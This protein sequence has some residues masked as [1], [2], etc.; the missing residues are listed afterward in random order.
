MCSFPSPNSLPSW[1]RR[2]TPAQQRG[3]EAE[4]QAADYLCA[5]G[6][7]VIAR[8]IRFKVGEL[9]LIMHDGLTI[10]FVEVR[11]RRAATDRQGGVIRG[12]FG[13]AAETISRQKQRRLILAAEC[14]LIQHRS[15]PRPPCRFDVVAIDGVVIQWIP[16]AFG[17][18]GAL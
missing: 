9:D 11:S 16:N 18:D 8:N 5:R 12:R 17:L 13:G 14:W 10:V 1:R 4:Q 2:L 6:L 7:I 3:F 15:H